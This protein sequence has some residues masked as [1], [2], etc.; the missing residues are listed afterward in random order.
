MN[1]FLEFAK[2]YFIGLFF[3]MIFWGI[4][5]FLLNTVLK[6]FFQNKHASVFASLV[7]GIILTVTVF[8]IIITGFKTINLGFLLLFSFSFWELRKWPVVNKEKKNEQFFTFKRFLGFAVAYLIFFTWEAIF[9]FKPGEFSLVLPH[10]DFIFSSNISESLL[11][12]GNENFFMEGN[13]YNSAYQYMIPYHYFEIWLNSFVVYFTGTNNLVTFMLC[14]FPVLYFTAWMGIVSLFEQFIDK[15]TTKEYILSF[16]LLFAGGLIIYLAKSDFFYNLHTLA[17]I[18]MEF[19]TRK[20]IPFYIFIIAGLL[21]MINK[22]MA[23]G[24]LVILSLSLVSITAFPPIF[25]GFTLFFLVNIF[26]KWV[27]KQTVL[28][29]VFYLLGITAFITL[30]Y[31]YFNRS[32]FGL[33]FTDQKNGILTKVLSAGHLKIFFHVLVGAPVQTV[34]LYLPFLILSYFV[35]RKMKFLKWG[36][37]YLVPF[38]IFLS[39]IIASLFIWAFLWDMTNA[40]GFYASSL[41]YL[42][43]LIIFSFILYYKR[44]QHN[45]APFKHFFLVGFILFLFLRLGLAGYYN[46][47]QTK[48]NAALYSDQYLKK[49][50]DIAKKENLNPYG[51]F[52]MNYNDKNLFTRNTFFIRLGQYLKFIP[53]MNLA[54]NIGI[55]N[56]P[57]SADSLWKKQELG[58]I[59]FSVFY[60]FVEDQKKNN[61]F[62]SID[63]SQLDFIDQFHINYLITD[64]DTKLSPLLQKRIKTEITDERSGE[65]FILLNSE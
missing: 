43:I 33:V 20:Y 22:K 59:Q 24:M 37:E 1:V 25:A 15:I 18:P 41:C 45:P 23:P 38:Y 46:W 30:T 7:L 9:L 51:V 19:A 55:L 32:S 49:V 6:R 35:L 16:L 57:P 10:S 52:I 61:Q 31:F 2:Y 56:T 34:V 42:N 17:P 26:F 53:Q 21:F 28:R 63:Q 27:D 3:L 60:Q 62:T 48:G 8:S 14:S 39:I 64:K 4:G 58:L 65:R 47:G 12:Q 54:T 5:H 11:K 44:I 40:A 13:F 29:L 36:K 50:G